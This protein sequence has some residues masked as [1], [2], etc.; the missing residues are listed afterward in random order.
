MISDMWKKVCVDVFVA[1][2]TY[3]I[4]LPCQL[5]D[6]VEYGMLTLCV[7]CILHCT[8]SVLAILFTHLLFVT[9]C[10]FSVLCV[11][12][13]MATSFKSNADEWQALWLLAVRI[14]WRSLSFSIAIQHTMLQCTII[15]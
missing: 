1:I 7:L 5:L 10:T 13:T 8:L 11:S 4:Q 3:F 14:Y 9:T 12:S 6:S 2:C 15:L